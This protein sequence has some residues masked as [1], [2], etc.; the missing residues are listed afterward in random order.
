[1]VAEAALDKERKF[2][3]SELDCRFLCEAD[4]YTNLFSPFCK[5][6]ITGLKHVI[7][8]TNNSNVIQK[9]RDIMAWSEC[10]IKDQ[11]I[12]LFNFR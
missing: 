4:T 9:N 6:A 7:T 11:A 5:S 1:M 2:A 10:Y 8:L 12:F 3:F